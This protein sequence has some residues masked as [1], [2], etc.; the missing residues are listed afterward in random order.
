MPGTSSGVENRLQ[1]KWP[2]LNLDVL[3][4]NELAAWLRAYHNENIVLLSKNANLEATVKGK[5]DKSIVM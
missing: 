3:A 2:H 1:H 4:Q 5:F